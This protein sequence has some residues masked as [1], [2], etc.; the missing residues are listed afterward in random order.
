MIVTVLAARHGLAAAGVGMEKPALRL[1]A[2]VA[3][4]AVGYLIGAMAF[5]RASSRALVARVADALRART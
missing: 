5:A 3:A 2:E 4:G 1:L